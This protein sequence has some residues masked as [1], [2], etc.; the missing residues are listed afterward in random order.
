MKRFFSSLP[1]LVFWLFYSLPLYCQNYL[2]IRY[3]DGSD[4]N[5]PFGSLQKI[6][7]DRP[8]DKI[9]FILT[10][11]TAQSV[12]FNTIQKFT[13]SNFGEGTLLPVELVTFTTTV[14]HNTVALSWRT[15]TEVNNYGFEIER[16]TVNSS[17]SSSSSWK[18]VGF[19]QGN[20]I[21]NTLHSYSFT[22]KNLSAGTY[23]Y[24]LK[25]IDNGGAF[26]YSQETEVTLGVPSVFTLNQNFPNPFNPQTTIA[27]TIPKEC[28]VTI[29]VYD[30]LGKEVSSLVHE[31]NKAGSYEATFDGS[32]LASGMYICR[33][34]AATYCSATK[35]IILK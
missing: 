19:V 25:Q 26:K 15:A 11:A 24:R 6:T 10:D 2:N 30:V 29:K 7:F 22:D 16:R 17:Q 13:T 23:V 33:M 1:I 21:S 31:N 8:G 4:Q 9:N 14:N 32:R 18:K 5:V 28:F 35:M 27:Y 20:G 12:A 34:S 3:T